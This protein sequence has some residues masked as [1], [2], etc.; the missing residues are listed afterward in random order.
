MGNRIV[1]ELTGD[2]S[3]GV[4]T[5]GKSNGRNAMKAGLYTSD[6]TPDYGVYLGGFLH[7]TEKCDSIEDPLFLRI[8]ALEDDK[9][10][11]VLLITADL[12]LFPIDFSWRIRFWAR[13]TY[14]IP[15]SAVILN[16]SHTHY[17]PLLA[18]DYWIN[19]NKSNLQ[20][21]TDLEL[22]IRNG[23]ESAL[24]DLVPCAIDSGIMASDIGINRRLR[25]PGSDQVGTDMRPN[26]DGYYDPDLPIL[27]IYDENREHLKGLFYSYA[28]HPTSQNIPGISA[29]YPGAIALALSEIYDESVHTLFAQGAGANIKTRFYDPET[30][31]FRGATKDELQSLGQKVANNIKEFVASDKMTPIVLDLK[32]AESVFEVPYDLSQVKSID[33]YMEMMDEED[34]LEC[35]IPEVNKGFLSYMIERIRTDTMPKG[36]DL[37]MTMVKLCDEIQIIG[38]S[39]EIAAELGRMVKDLF[40]DQKTIFLGYCYEDDYYVPSKSMILEGGYETDRS[41]YLGLHPGRY[42]LEIDDIIKRNALELNGQLSKGRG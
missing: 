33:E 19:W 26:E 42:I 7:R 5:T 25:L 38:M 17:G 3:S 12:H 24:T 14:D 32:H 28:C 39:C 21:V 22:E 6:I 11:R 35:Q 9:G 29:D 20:F 37:H 13:K 23:I 34:P 2:A 36:N 8:L 18:Y 4:A 16:T 27:A 30:R 41:R 1:T 10:C 31:Y 40:P 15:Y